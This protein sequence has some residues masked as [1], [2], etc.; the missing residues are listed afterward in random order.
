MQPTTWVVHI[1][2][3][4]LCNFDVFYENLWERLTFSESRFNLDI[5]QLAD[6]R[7]LRKTEKQFWRSSLSEI[8]Y[9]HI[10]SSWT[11]AQFWFFADRL[12]FPSLIF[13]SVLS[14]F[15][16]HHQLGKNPS[17]KTRNT[18]NSPCIK[19][20]N[21]IFTSGKHTTRQYRGFWADT[22]FHPFHS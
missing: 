8:K 20:F 6:E 5:V 9:K 17:R 14:L 2:S 18:D 15:F 11:L 4:L 21:S 19:Q 10:I 1:I 22:I 16:S 13:T 7:T 3:L 12:F